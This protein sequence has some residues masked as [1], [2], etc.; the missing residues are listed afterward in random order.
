M[1][2]KIALRGGEAA[3]KGRDSAGSKSKADL[4]PFQS[5]DSPVERI[6][7]LQRTIGNRAVT[8]LI[9]SGTLGEKEEEGTAQQVMRLVAPGEDCPECIEEGRAQRQVDEKHEEDIQTRRIAGQVTPLVQYA[10]QKE[11]F[12][13]LSRL[14]DYR[15]SRPEHDPS[16]LSDADI[17]ATNEYQ[18]YMNPRLVWQ[19]RDRVT[20]EEALLACRLMLRHMRQGH[21]VNWQREARLFMNRARR[22]LG[23]LTA[24]EALGGNLS[25]TGSVTWEQQDISLTGTEFGRWL[26]SGGPEPSP[27]SGTMNCWEVILFG[28]HRAGYI[29]RSRLADFYRR[30]TARLTATSASGDD[31]MA[32]VSIENE[33]R[34]GS[35]HAFDQAD[36]DSPSPL[37]GDIVV[38]DTAVNHTA[39]SLGTITGGEHDVLSL[40]DRPNNH[41]YLQRTTI[42]ELLREGAS[43]PVKFWSPGW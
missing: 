4:S 13:Q 36:P 40:W 34:A 26:L 37:R 19:R 9:E 6:L 28:A 3:K 27:T 41:L 38:F 22:Q 15:D 23:T 18:A 30:F 10:V 20:R 21:R 43:T 5:A 29:N 11:S 1:A 12:I 31:V 16:R 25:G 14:R 17:E 42:E 2:E 8:R 24:V 35:E 7:F 32:D 39:I 33:F